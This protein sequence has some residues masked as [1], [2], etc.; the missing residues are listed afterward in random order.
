MLDLSRTLDCPGA[1]RLRERTFLNRASTRQLL[2][3][4]GNPAQINIAQTR[5][6]RPLFHMHSNPTFQYRVIT[7]IQLAPLPYLRNTFI[8]RLKVVPVDEIIPHCRYHYLGS[9]RTRHSVSP[10]MTPATRGIT[11]TASCQRPSPLPISGSFNSLFKVLCNFPSR[12]L[13]AIGLQLIFRV[14][15]YSPAVFILYSQTV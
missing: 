11:V 12:Y 8:G 9:G 14:N 4:Y 13:C 1:S 3:H 2:A 6:K 5:Q 10:T 7:C 15:R